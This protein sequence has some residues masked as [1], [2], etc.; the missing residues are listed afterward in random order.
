MFTGI[1]EKK[2]KILSIEDGMFTLENTLGEIPTIGQSIAHDGAC[3]TITRAD[4]ESYSFFSMAESMAVTNYRAKKVG[5]MM[6]VERCLR[7]GDRIDGHIVSG[8]VDRVGSVIDRREIP[9][10]SLILTISRPEPESHYTIR[11]GSITINGVSLTITEDTNTS[12][13]VSLIPLTQDFTNLGNLQIG[14]IVNL[15]YDMF[16]KYAEK[17]T[18]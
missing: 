18:H 4:A 7:I 13:S 5:D 1:I 16:A 3:M 2:A 6:N 12:I 14:D 15:E 8:H 9:D 10:G 17:Y 11:K